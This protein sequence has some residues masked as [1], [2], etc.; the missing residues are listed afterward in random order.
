M[1]S[2]VRSRGFIAIIANPDKRLDYSN[3]DEEAERY[4][5]EFH[6][7]LYDDKTGLALSNDGRL[8]Y[9]DQLKH[10]GWAIREDIYSLEL[11]SIDID[12]AAEFTAA[13]ETWK[14]N[15]IPG[16]IVPYSCIWYNASESPMARLTVE[17]FCKK[18]GVVL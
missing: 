18:T 6:D 16:S 13:C 1:S 10:A 14:L 11:G 3:R 7:R 2:T 4:R 5:E 9:I 12:G 17:E 15:V 8:V